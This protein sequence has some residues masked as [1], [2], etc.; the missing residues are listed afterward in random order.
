[1]KIGIVGLGIIGSRMAANWRKAGHEIV[2]L[3]W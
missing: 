3:I 1:M 2:G